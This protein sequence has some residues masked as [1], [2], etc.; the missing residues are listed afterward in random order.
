LE[1]MAVYT[2]YAN[3]SKDR[4]AGNKD[5]AAVLLDGDFKSAFP[6]GIEFDPS[7]KAALFEDGTLLQQSSQYQGLP[8]DMSGLPKKARWGGAKRDLDDLQMEAGYFLVSA[9]MRDVIE[10]LE[11][12][13]HQFQPVEL[14][15]K[16]GNHATDFFWFNICNRVDA[17]DREQTTHPFNERIGCWSFVEG[18]KFVVRSDK[19]SRIHVWVESRLTT[20]PIFV[21]EEFKVT[22]AAAGI[23]GIGFNIVETI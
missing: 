4:K 8:V 2:I 21:S 15:W 7:I 17:M 18:R 1:E 22:M 19:I 23:S 12:G 5:E 3:L 20:S 14:N 9:K 10:T 6:S 11:P 16:D 13:I